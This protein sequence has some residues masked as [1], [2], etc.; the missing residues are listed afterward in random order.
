[1]GHLLRGNVVG[2]LR[3]AKPLQMVKR[4]TDIEEEEIA[5]S[6]ESILTTYFTLFYAHFNC[7][8]FGYTRTSGAGCLCA[9]PQHDKCLV[10]QRH[11]TLHN[12]AAPL[13]T[14]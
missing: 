10:R 8:L 3:G 14:L 5:A 11:T 13:L 9:T 2:I 4:D 7:P 12:A 6:D 1:M